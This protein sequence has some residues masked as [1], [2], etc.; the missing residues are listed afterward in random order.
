[1]ANPDTVPESGEEPDWFGDQP[2][3]SIPTQKP[4]PVI[5]PNDRDAPAPADTY[6][7]LNVAYGGSL[8]EIG[9]YPAFAYDPFNAPSPFAPPSGQ[10][11]LDNDPGYDFR[12]GQGRQALEQSAAAR[13]VLNTGGTLQDLINYGQSFASNEY[14]NAYQRALGT[15]QTNFNDALNAYITNFGGAL[16]KYNTNYGTQYLTPYNQLMEQYG[17]RN[18]NYQNAQDRSFGQQ[19]SVATA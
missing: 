2:P 15:Y 9:T 11:V 7:P 16:T 18:S 5:P 4:P 8:P 12:L 14:D 10:S 1:M 13:G 19:L 6:G 17:I 3:P